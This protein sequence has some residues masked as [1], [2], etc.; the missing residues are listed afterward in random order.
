MKILKI[1]FAIIV[2]V[3][4]GYALFEWRYQMLVNE[5]TAILDKQCLNV[6]PLI[7]QR[8][9]SYL[10]FIRLIYEKAS[11]EEVEKE[12]KTYLTTSE[13]FIVEQKKWLNEQNKFMNRWDFKLIL[14][15]EIHKLSQLDY[16]SKELDVKIFENILKM[17][18]TE[19]LNEQKKYYEENVNFLKTIEQINKEIDEIYRNKPNF[20]WRTIFVKAQSSKCPKENLDILNI[21]DFFQPLDELKYGLSS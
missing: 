12:F 5:G 3:V 21:P 11:K 20:S 13:K 15:E 16:R 14:L 18:K 17:A 8:K 6:D 9:N 4:L 19:N 2:F 1:I 10:N 7:I